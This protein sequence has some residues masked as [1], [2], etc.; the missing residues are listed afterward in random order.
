M[1]GRIAP[2]A[3]K[4]PGPKG[5]SQAANEKPMYTKSNGANQR[6]RTSSFLYHLR[7]ICVSPGLKVEPVRV[8]V[9]TW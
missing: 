4:V 5:Y 9:I 7:G 2:Q 6:F 8:S 1:N 3:Q